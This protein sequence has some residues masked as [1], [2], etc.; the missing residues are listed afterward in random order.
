MRIVARA[1]AKLSPRFLLQC[2][3]REEIGR[4][5]PDQYRRASVEFAVELLRDAGFS[6]IFVTAPKG[7]SRPLV[8]GNSYNV[9]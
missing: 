2:N 1:V 4:E 3:I 5:E 8:D 7:Y 6:S 9:Q